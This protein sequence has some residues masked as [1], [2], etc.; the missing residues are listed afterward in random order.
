MKFDAR[1]QSGHT[2]RIDTSEVQ[3]GEGSA[4][5]PMELQLVAL[6]GCGAMD[7]ISILRKM[8]EDVR[9][10]DVRVAAERATEHPKVY[11]S[12]VVAHR[13]TGEG[14]GEANVRRA[15]FLS[16]S[17]YCPVFNMLAPGVAIREL[18]EIADTASGE[19]TAGEVTLADE[20]V[21]VAR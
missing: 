21:A 3:G 9:T 13:F 6:G 14:I 15:I 18:Y 20:D 8:R 7:V 2:L 1:T 11:T 10:Y 5:G 19:V 4:P 16:M 12:A 17:R